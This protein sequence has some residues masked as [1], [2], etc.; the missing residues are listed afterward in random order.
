MSDLSMN[1]KFGQALQERALGVQI[2]PELRGG[3]LPPVQGREL[4][5]ALRSQ[6]ISLYH[7]GHRLFRPRERQGPAR[8]LKGVKARFLVIAFKSDWLYPAYQSQEIARACKRAGVEATYAELEFDLGPRRLSHRS[9][10]AGPPDKALP[11]RVTGFSMTESKARPEMHRGDRTR[12]AP[13]CST[14]AAAAASCSPPWPKRNRSAAR[15]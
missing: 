1:E 8:I 13:R 15:A 10:G 6:L 5:Q 11:Q 9:G 12:P 14:W 2:R 4:H 3:G 7:K